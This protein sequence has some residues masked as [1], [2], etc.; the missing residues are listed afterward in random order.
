MLCIVEILDEINVVLRGVKHEHIEYVINKTKKL[1]K[2]ARHTARY[3]VG[4]WD[5]KRS[6][7]TQ[8]GNT[9]LF[10]LPTILPMLEKFGYTFELVDHRSKESLQQEH[11]DKHFIDGFIL[12]DPQ[13]EAVNAVID[14]KKGILDVATAAGKT[15]ISA[16]TSKYFNRPSIVIVPSNKLL[17]QTHNDFKKCDLDVGRVGGK[18]KEWEHKHIIATYQTLKNHRE[19]INRDTKVIQID[20]IHAYMS[21]DGVVDTILRNELRNAPVRIGLTGTVPKDKQHKE[22]LFTRLG[23]EIIYTYKPKEG[24]E[25]GY[26][27]TLEISQHS[28][29][30][31]ILIESDWEREFRY[32]NRNEERLIAISNWI[33]ELKHDKVLILT[34][35]QAGIYIADTLGLDFIDQET[36]EDEREAC[37]K[38]MDINDEPYYLVASYGTASTGISMDKIQAVVLIDVGKTFSRIIQSIGRGLR[39]D[40]VNNH[41]IVYDLYAKLIKN[42]KGKPYSYGFSLKHLKERR[43]IFKE[44]EYQYYD[45]ES[46]YV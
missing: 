45:G 26:L 5:G 37:Y 20:E 7:L 34:H 42:Y 22:V 13:V 1:V 31:E 36:P 15:L 8:H 43:K 19:R 12:R 28:I 4:A 32:Y 30:H 41:L 3:K 46:I 25:D 18:Y 35:P 14:H 24:I 44:Y 39:L 29:V 16:A 11:I 23:G 9:F 27:S 10:M 40:G 6:Q 2:G 38:K 33:D 17:I 21:E